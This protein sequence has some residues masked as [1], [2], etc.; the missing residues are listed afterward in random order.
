[1]EKK[2]VDLISDINSKNPQTYI[3]K[4][5]NKLLDTKPT[6]ESLVKTLIKEYTN[7]STEIKASIDKFINESEK[8]IIK[9]GK[10]K[11]QFQNYLE[12]N[13]SFFE[14]NYIE[15]KCSAFYKRTRTLSMSI[16]LISDI[17][18]AS[19][20]KK[21]SQKFKNLLSEKIN[22]KMQSYESTI[23]TTQEQLKELGWKKVSYIVKEN[24]HTLTLRKNS[25]EEIEIR[26]R[27]LSTIGKNL[28]KFLEFVKS[29]NS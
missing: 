25:Q 2:L 4:V 16:D 18:V 10:E 1:M 9:N 26:G 14:T 24:L 27:S 11:E 23:F 12:N 21:S 29:K 8:V 13:R 3:Y 22:A 5:V 28:K 17:S 20:I 6:A 19:E 15:N 7:F